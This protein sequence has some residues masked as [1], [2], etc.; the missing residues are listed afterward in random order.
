MHFRLHVL[1]VI[2]VH[3]EQGIL[4]IGFFFLEV[5]NYRIIL[6]SLLE[7]LIICILNMEASRRKVP[8]LSRSNTIVKQRMED[9]MLH[10][11]GRA[12]LKLHADIEA[13]RTIWTRVKSKGVNKF[14]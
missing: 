14:R 6:P 11:F 1:H 12:A 4:R 8:G 9:V 2:L 5:N 3:P 10:K 7:Y 13:F